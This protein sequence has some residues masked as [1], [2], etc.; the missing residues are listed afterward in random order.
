MALRARQVLLSTVGPLVFVQVRAP[1]EAPATS[2]AHEG[3]LACVCPPVRAEVGAVAEALPTLGTGVRPLPSVRPA[4]DDQAGALAE[5]LPALRARVRLLTRVD[6]LVRAEVGA[7]TEALP[8]HLTFVGPLPGV[9]ALVLGQVG[10]LAKALAALGAHI[11]LFNV[12]GS[13]SFQ[14]LLRPGHALA[15]LSV[16]LPSHRHILP[17]VLSILKWRHKPWDRESTVPEAFT[18]RGD[19]SSKMAE[20]GRP[21]H[22]RNTRVSLRALSRGVSVRP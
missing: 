6:P 17:G 5:A 20:A 13:S 3:L 11:R 1:A 8:A 14:R 21:S 16:L 19:A 10:R 7:V 15:W 18:G 2:R 4:V 22:L 12:S 9:C